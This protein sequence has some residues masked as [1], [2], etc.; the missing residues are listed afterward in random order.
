MKKTNLTKDNRR[1]GFTLIEMLIAMGLFGVVSAISAGGFIQAFRTQRQ[2]AA[3][4]AA[5]DAVAFAI[6]QMTR[7]IRTGTNFSIPAVG[8]IIFKNDSGQDIA[9]CFDAVNK[10]LARSSSGDCASAV[11]LTGTSVRVNSVDYDFAAQ[12]AG[13]PMRV[14]IRMSVSPTGDPAIANSSFKLQTTVSPRNL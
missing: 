1:S 13:F 7:E 3:M 5:N 11:R 10:Y 4:Y 12:A 2:T 6:E 14:V 8:Q 9:Y